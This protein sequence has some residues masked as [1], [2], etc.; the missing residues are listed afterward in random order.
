[1]ARIE[2]SSNHCEVFTITEKA[3]TKAFSWLKMLWHLRHYNINLLS[4]SCLLTMIVKSL[5]RFV[6][7]SSL[8]GKQWNSQS[9][10]YI[11][12]YTGQGLAINF[13]L[14]NKLWCW[15][16]RKFYISCFII[17]L[18]VKCFDAEYL[19]N[20]N[21]WNISRAINMLLVFSSSLPLWISSSLFRSVPMLRL[22]G[23]RLQNAGEQ[24]QS[25]L[26]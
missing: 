13:T 7:G 6:G 19:V 16:I 23:L 18:F 14:F 20:K 26:I 21:N 2:L 12:E 11:N 24:N 17:S 25:D 3:P 22:C 8:V 9:T 15:R 5:Q 1:M 4:T 10:F